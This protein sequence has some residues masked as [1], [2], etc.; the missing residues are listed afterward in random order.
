M[1]FDYQIV[2]APGDELIASGHTVHAAVN[3][4]GRPA[5]LPD[6]VT[7]LFA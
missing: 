1:Q 2:R 4:Q 3:A 6:R 7:G 5:R